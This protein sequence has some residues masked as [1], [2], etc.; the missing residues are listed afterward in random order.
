[1]QRITQPGLHALFALAMYMAA[2]TANAATA[3]P[4]AEFRQFCQRATHHAESR[5]ALPKDL[6]TAISFTESGQWDAA[7]Q[8][9]IAWPWTVTT[10]GKGRF[11]PDKQTAIEFVRDLQQR[12]VRN[13]DVGCMQV[14]LRFHPDAFPDLEAAFDPKI[15]AL[16]AAQFLGKLH[17]RNKSW[18][19]AIGRYH[20]SNQRRGAAY[21]ERVLGF[22]NKT[23][24][25]SAE[26]H[27]QT[28][29]AAY[30]Q[31]RAEREQARKLK[32]LAR[33]H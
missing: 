14:N 33:S 20:S 30:L 26:L 12:G 16:Y 7:K 29:V 13:I 2:S 23:Q 24:R 10:G 4:I 11:F 1:M 18:S 6:L 32:A 22:W 9:I 31:K 17:D 3:L 25:N 27:R 15:N 19:D 21:R 5:N 8:A 28:V